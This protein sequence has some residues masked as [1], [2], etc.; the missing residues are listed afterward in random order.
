MKKINE[1]DLKSIKSRGSNYTDLSKATD[2]FFRMAKIEGDDEN[3]SGSSLSSG[4][5]KE[6]E[7]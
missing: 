1:I 7:K 2:D 4:D 5:E 6:E 3:D